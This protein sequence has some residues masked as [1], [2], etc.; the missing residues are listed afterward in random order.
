MAE[1]IP[2]WEWR[3]FTHQPDVEEKISQYPLTRQVES[4]DVYIL[5][6][7]SMEN[8]K[9]RNDLMDIKSLQVVTKDGLEQWKPVKKEK[10]PL[11]L[12]EVQEMFRTF[13]VPMPKFL[14]DTCS[15]DEFV[16]LA[17]KDDRIICVTVDKS[18]R[19]YDVDGCIVEVADLKI[20]GRSIMTVAVE[21]ED[22]D[23]VRETIKMLGLTGLENMNYVTAI[24]R[25]HKGEL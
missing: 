20:A 3:T 17:K 5:S 13:R 1:I 10:F 18:R 4:S 23:K 11:P 12:S 7:L 25:M 22:P 8:T 14:K 24:K 21:L 6:E 9:V 16:E 2:R 15:F 19:L